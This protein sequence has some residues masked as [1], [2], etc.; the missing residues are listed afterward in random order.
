MELS[1]GWAWGCGGQAEVRIVGPPDAGTVWTPMSLR[2]QEGEKRDVWQCWWG[3]W[4][5]GSGLSKFDERGRRHARGRRACGEGRLLSEEGLRS[6]QG[7]KLALWEAR[8]PRAGLWGVVTCSRSQQR[9]LG[10]KS[11]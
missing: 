6:T 8:R 10:T 4:Q 9:S 2:L 5:G 3:W 7:G 11:V 1:R